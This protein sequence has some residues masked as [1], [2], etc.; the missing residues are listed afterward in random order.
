MSAMRKTALVLT[1]AL[2]LGVTLS[3]GCALILFAGGAAA[4]AGAVA[5]MNGELQTTEAIPLDKACIAA[6]AA[7]KN[8]GYTVTRKDE[9]PMVSTKFAAKKGEQ[10]VEITLKSVGDKVTQIGVR[11][12]VFGDRAMSN[13]ILAEIKKELK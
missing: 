2:C 10:R 9:S 5:Y 13:V 1:L 6:Q 4:G 11:V 3:S 12:G 8:M 7:L